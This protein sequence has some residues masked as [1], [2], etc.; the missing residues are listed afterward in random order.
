MAKEAGLRK[1]V[2]E[3]KK[4]IKDGKVKK[5]NNWVKHGNSKPSTGQF[6]KAAHQPPLSSISQAGELNQ[7]SK[8]AKAMLEVATKSTADVENDK[9]LGLPTIY[10][11][12]E[13]QREFPSTTTKQFRKLLA[14]TISQDNVVSALKLTILDTIPRFKFNSSKNYRD[15]RNNR[16]SKTRHAIFERNFEQHS[17]DLVNKWFNHLQDKGVMTKADLD[18]LTAWIDNKGFENQTD[19]HRMQVSKLL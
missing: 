14:R 2:K 7:N 3:N 10:V 16:L 1:T 5:Y 8:L 13:I 17:K 18:T 19:P 15:F 4:V 12:T 6:F 9:G 11:P